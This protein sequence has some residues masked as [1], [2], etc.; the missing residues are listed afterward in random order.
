M[1]VV[2]QGDFLTDPPKSH[3]IFK[4]KDGEARLYLVI[5]TTSAKRMKRSAKAITAFKPCPKSA[6]CLRLLYVYTCD[7]TG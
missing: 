7:A 6:K 5:N 1:F 2:N 3:K 4:N